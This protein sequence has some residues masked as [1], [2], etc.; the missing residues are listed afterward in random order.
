MANGFMK[1]LQEDAKIVK[2]KKA[3][4]FIE[5][6]G[7][8]YYLMIN[9]NNIISKSKKIQIKRNYKRLLRTINLRERKVKN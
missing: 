6:R 9:K 2:T 3:L 8:N 7:K 4:K 5:K 1:R